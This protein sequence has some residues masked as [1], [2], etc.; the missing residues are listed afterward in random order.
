ME[1]SQGLI[2][3]V[4]WALT[5]SRVKNGRR[6]VTDIPPMPVTSDSAA[7]VTTTDAHATTASLTQVGTAQ[8][9]S[10][11]EPLIPVPIAEAPTQQPSVD[12]QL[13]GLY[14]TTTQVQ[15]MVMFLFA[16]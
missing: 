13:G 6:Q 12:S 1:R 3:I 15:M 14:I 16:V 7:P 10:A 11:P 9:K 8:I 5:G 2:T 4:F